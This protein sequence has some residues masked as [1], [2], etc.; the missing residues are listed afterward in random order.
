VQSTH[1]LLDLFREDS[2][3]VQALGRSAANA[4]RVFNALSARPLATIG[5]L[6]T[7]TG[8]SYP[9]A[10]RAVNALEGLGI[11]R[12]ITGRKRERVFAYGR[13]LEILSEG[14]EPL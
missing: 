4:L 10:A 2:A 3:R 8:T 1:R 12:E 9:T 13:Y 5:S 6:S 11:V 7:G 14:T